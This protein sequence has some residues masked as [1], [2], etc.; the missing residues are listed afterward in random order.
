MDQPESDLLGPAYHHPGQAADVPGNRLAAL[1]LAEMLAVR[2]KPCQADRPALAGRSGIDRP[3]VL[4]VVG[5]IG[6]VCRVHQHRLGIV[7]D[8]DVDRPAE[9]KLDPGAGPAAAGEV[10][11][12]QLVEK[13]W[14]DCPGHGITFTPAPVLVLPLPPKDNSSWRS[15]RRSP[16]ASFP[17]PGW[18]DLHPPPLPQPKPPRKVR[19][20]KTSPIRDN[21][22]P[23]WH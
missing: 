3:D 21:A 16:P 9:R 6:M 17:L 14:L 23:R 15:L 22:L 1:G 19:R 8:G 7:I 10:V 20:R 11:D 13:G 18:Q 5:R 2:G 12:D 4:A